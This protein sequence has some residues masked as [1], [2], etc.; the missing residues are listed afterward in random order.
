M[1]DPS[2]AHQLI[3]FTYPHIGNYGVNENAMESDEI[4]ARAAIMRSAVN[5]ED[6][7]D[8][9]RGWLDWLTDCGIP[10]ISGVDTRAL[11]RHIRE[12]G[13]MRGGVFPE[14][15][16]E[17]QAME[18]I[19]AEPPMD[20]AGP[21]ARRDP[22]RADGPRPGQPDAHPRD[23]HRHQ[24]LDRAQPRRAR[25]RGD[26]AP[27]HDRRRRAAVHRRG[28]VL[29]GQRP[30]RPGRAGLH[31]RHGPRASSASARCGASAWATS[32]SAAPSASRP[33]SCRSATAA[34][35]TRSSTSRPARSRSPRRTTASRSWA[36]TGAPGSRPTSR[37]AGRPTSAPR[38]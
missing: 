26:A 2:F 34:P 35:T 25:R 16:S 6:A 23:R 27:V 37:C 10:A 3:T 12:A 9:E 7:P 18:W 33:R 32:C 8:A 14:R 15:I 38:R 22:E 1:T 11:V 17:Q 24:A 13:A 30:R 31:R 5:Y 20:R 29:P 36:P 28:R 4:W 21:G 19:Q